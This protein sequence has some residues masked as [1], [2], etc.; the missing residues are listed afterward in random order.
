MRRRHRSPRGKNARTL[1]SCSGRSRRKIQGYKPGRRDRRSPADSSLHSRSPCSRT[2][3]SSRSAQGH[4]CHWGC[5][6]LRSSSGRSRTTELVRTACSGSCSSLPCRRKN[7]TRTTSCHSCKA[8]PEARRTRQRYTQRRSLPDRP[9]WSH[10]PC[11]CVRRNMSETS[12]DVGQVHPSVSLSPRPSP[13]WSYQSSRCPSCPVARPREAVSRS[14]RLGSHPDHRR[15]QNLSRPRM[16][17]LPAHP[18][19][20]PSAMNQPARCTRPACN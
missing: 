15:R 13:G 16:P 20:R 17:R 7:R 11:H 6:R 9:C 14:A 4:R 1:H 12:R 18:R 2:D 3:R 19:L 10:T 5:K 8:R